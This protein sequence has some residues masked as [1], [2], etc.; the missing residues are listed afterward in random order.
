MSLNFNSGHILVPMVWVGPKGRAERGSGTQERVGQ[1][2][3][4]YDKAG[5]TMHGSAGLTDDWGAVGEKDKAADLIERK[6][7]LVM[8][9]ILVAGG[10]NLEGSLQ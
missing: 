3:E 10:K 4:A 8:H 1:G 5:R 9:N 6:F 7:V 2:V